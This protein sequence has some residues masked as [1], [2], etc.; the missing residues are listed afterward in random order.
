VTHSVRNFSKFENLFFSE[1]EAI[2]NSRC[3]NE[4]SN[5]FWFKGKSIV[6]IVDTKDFTFDDIDMIKSKNFFQR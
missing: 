3:S 1:N 5:F 6:S 4:G 2:R